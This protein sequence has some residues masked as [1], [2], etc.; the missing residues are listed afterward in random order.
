MELLSYLGQVTRRRAR[1]EERARDLASDFSSVDSM[2]EEMRDRSAGLV[3]R[4]EHDK[5]RFEEFQRVAADDTV[6]SALAGIRLGGGEK[7]MKKDASF[8][9]STKSLPYLWRFYNDIQEGMGTGRIT[10]SLSKETEIIS[11]PTRYAPR[12][13]SAD[14][15]L[16]QEII[17]EMP[18]R[19]ID[20]TTGK[21]IPA[22]WGG[23]QSRLDRYLAYPIFGWE[24]Y[25]EM[26]NKRTLGFKEARRVANLDKKC[27]D[28]CR[29]YSGQGWQPIGYFPPPGQ[30][31][32]CHDRCRCFMEFR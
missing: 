29:S 22:T 5:I 6:T 2:E 28:D 11:S 10:Q 14:N 13:L 30:G 19:D 1:F 32:R 23:V 8:S 4:L 21:A 12:A 18:T 9:A 27:C 3:Y 16:M 15:D 17:D 7:A 25:G 26:D 31:C 20:K 24:Q